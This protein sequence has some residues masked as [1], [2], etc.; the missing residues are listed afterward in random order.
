MG[1][2]V[3]ATAIRHRPQRSEHVTYFPRVLWTDGDAEIWSDEG[4][5]DQVCHIFKRLPI[6][7]A[8]KQRPTLENADH[9]QTASKDKMGHTFCRV[10]TDQL[11]AWRWAPE[12]W[13]KPGWPAGEKMASACRTLLWICMSGESH[14]YKLCMRDVWKTLT[15][16]PTPTQA[17]DTDPL[18]SLKICWGTKQTKMKC[19]HFLHAHVAWLQIK[20][21]FKGT[22]IPIDTVLMQHLSEHVSMNKA[23]GQ[24]LFCNTPAEDHIEMCQSSAHTRWMYPM[25]KS[26]DVAF[27]EHHDSKPDHPGRVFNCDKTLCSGL[28]RHKIWI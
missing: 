3:Y 16:V 23:P 13:S 22:V 5:V 20:P 27:W 28:S 1:I 4:V 12:M 24:P 25:F 2:Q 10:W 11:L 21:I 7:L 6:I 8:A 19:R 17:N 9:T 14:S 18:R 26:F 15:P